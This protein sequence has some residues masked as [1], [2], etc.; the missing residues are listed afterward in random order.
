MKG[1]TCPICGGD[2]VKTPFGYGCS[3]YNKDDPE[4]SC[5]FNLGKIAGYKLKDAQVKELLTSGITDTISGFKSKNGNAFEAKLAL[6]RDET[7]KVTGVRFVF[8]NEDETLEGL[9]CPKCGKNIIKGHMGYRCED[10]SREEEGCKF[11]VGKI[12]GVE[13][14]KEQFTKLLTDKITDKIAGFNSKK[15]TTFEAK[16]KFDENFNIVFDFE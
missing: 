15:G 12:A 4:K 7:G 13:L 2:I 10:Y 6:S 1:G 8:E 11:F 14:T 5:K 9:K 3:N 16:L